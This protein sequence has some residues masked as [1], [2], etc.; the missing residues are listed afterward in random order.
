MTMKTNL[1][2]RTD[3]DFVPNASN[4]IDI[5]PYFQSEISEEKKK[6]WEDVEYTENEQWEP[7]VPELIISESRKVE[8]KRKQERRAKREEKEYWQAWKFGIFRIFLSLFKIILVFS[9]E[10]YQK[11]DRK[12]RA[13]EWGGINFDKK[14]DEQTLYYLWFGLP[15]TIKTVEDV[16][17]HFPLMNRKTCYRLLKI[18]KQK[19]EM[20]DRIFHKK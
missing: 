14:Y 10:R 18:R 19:L 2:V 15:M 9:I 12:L 11:W 6:D 8:E 16:L 1:S 7:F 3:P 4:T 5:R 17:L 20:Y 13:L